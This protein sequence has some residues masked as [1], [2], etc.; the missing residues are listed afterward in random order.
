MTCEGDLCGTVRAD[1]AQRNGR[2]CLSCG[3]SA[4][5]K[6]ARKDT[7]AERLIEPR[8]G[9]SAGNENA[10]AQFTVLL[11]LNGNPVSGVLGAEAEPRRNKSRAK[12]FEA[13]HA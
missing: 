10:L 13:D 5:L 6:D 11:P 3:E 8:V 12:L 1:D 9:V 4:A 7:T 2:I